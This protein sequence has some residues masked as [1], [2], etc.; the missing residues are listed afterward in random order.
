MLAGRRAL[1]AG[2]GGGIGSAV[3]HRFCEEGA[4]VVLAD[5]D[6]ELVSGLAADL[7]AQGYTAHALELDVTSEEAVQAATDRGAELLGGLD[8][9]VANAGTLAVGRLEEATVAEFRRIVEVNLIGTFSCLRYALPHLREA[10]NATIVCT[11]SQAGIQGAPELVSYCA[12]KFGVV[13][14]VEAL[15][16]ELAADGIR[17]NAVAP[18]LVDTPMLDAFFSRRGSIR[19]TSADRIAEKALEGV[20]LGRFAAPTEVAD[21]ILFLSSPQSSYISG[22]TL[23]ILG[24]E[25]A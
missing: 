8:A 23:P 2:A 10:D 14:M 25:P 21:A 17:V 5:L 24:G 7:R 20:P 13:G 16:R 11:A 4:E 9:L 1:L 22:I 12:S 18:G 6:L 19:G 3:A 15:G